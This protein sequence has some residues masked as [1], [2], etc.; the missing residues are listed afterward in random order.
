MSTED[1]HPV[2]VKVGANIR[3]RRKELR[4][5]QQQLAESIGLTFQQVQKYERGSNRVSASMLFEISRTLK[6]APA[7]FF[8][9]IV[10][11]SEDIGPLEAG[12]GKFLQSGEGIELAQWFPKLTSARRRAVVGLVRSMLPEQD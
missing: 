12:V 5:S 9:E 3:K 1:S 4:L 11:E 10:S 2:D 6:V 8:E 7:F